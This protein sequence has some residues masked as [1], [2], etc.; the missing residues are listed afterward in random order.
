MGKFLFQNVIWYHADATDESLLEEG[1]TEEEERGVERG[2]SDEDLTDFE[3]DD[4]SSSHDHPTI[5]VPCGRLEIG[6]L[7]S[8]L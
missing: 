7:T 6:E 3:E 1:D 4:V 5:H 2:F 8:T